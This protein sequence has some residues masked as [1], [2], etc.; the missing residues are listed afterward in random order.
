M[1]SAART[2]HTGRLDT[3]TVDGGTEGCRVL[4]TARGELVRGCTQPL[5]RAPAALPAGVAG[6]DVDASGVTLLETDTEL[7]HCVGGHGE[8]GAG[9]SGPA[10]AAADAPG[11]RGGPGRYGGQYGRTRPEGVLRSISC[12]RGAAGRRLTR[13][14]IRRSMTPS[15]C[16]QRPAGRR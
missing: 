5:T 1:V 9:R 12:P 14:R 13:T 7:R 10:G 4:L 16:R 2:P 6:A 11:R 8:R 3:L 15:C